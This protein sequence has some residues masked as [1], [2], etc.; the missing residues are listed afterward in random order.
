MIGIRNPHGLCYS[1]DA[2]MHGAVVGSELLRPVE[3]GLSM[4]PGAPPV[5]LS[6]TPWSEG[7]PTCGH[8]LA[9]H[10]TAIACG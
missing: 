4:T 6:D 2:F 5:I 7:S 8:L 3:A 10:V 9:Q 1:S